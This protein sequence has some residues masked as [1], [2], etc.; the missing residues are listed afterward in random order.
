MKKFC[1][2]L[3]FVIITGRSYATSQTIRIVGS[4]T[5][6]PYIIAAAEDFYRDHKDTNVIV[7]NTG[8]GIG[9]KLFCSSD[10]QHSPELVVSSRKMRPS[11]IEQCRNATGKV[12]ELE[13]GYDGIV[14]V[15]SK[16]NK[17][18]NLSRKEIFE[19]IAKYQLHEKNTT[20]NTNREWQE[21]NDSL[22]DYKIKVYGPAPSSGTREEID[23]LIMNYICKQYTSNNQ[24]YQ[25][26]CPQIR[27]DNM[28]AEIGKNENLIITKVIQNPTAIGITGY[29]F[30]IQNNKLVNAI[31]IDNISPNINTLIDMSYPLTRP[32]YIYAK[33]YQSAAIKNQVQ[34]FLK[35][36]ISD[37][38]VGY[39]GYLS[40]KGLI[41]L[42][43]KQ[44]NETRLKIDASF[45]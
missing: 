21:I 19:A 30:Y 27:Q 23:N 11:E 36:L 41:P 22:P 10:Q 37:F 1:F 44:I 33:N 9:F 3:L 31:Q 42:S 38:M 7:E 4:S 45:R 16:T 13:F 6:Y 35:R 20:L 12:V 40:S 18:A 29:N 34:T 5:A 17:I 25:K 39:D 8:S 32:L 26:L 43:K 2:L 14:F 24:D 15:S 28:F